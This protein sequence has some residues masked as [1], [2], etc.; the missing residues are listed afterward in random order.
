MKI[1]MF[2]MRLIMVLAGLGLLAYSVVLVCWLI[3]NKNLLVPPWLY[4]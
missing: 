2:V 1:E 4:R 3:V